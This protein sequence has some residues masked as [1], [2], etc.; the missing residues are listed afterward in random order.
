MKAAYWGLG[1]IFFGLFGLLLISL[2]GDIT[3]TNQQD[4]TLLKNTTEAALYDAV[5]E[6]AYQNGFCLCTNKAKVGGVYKFSDA[7]E[8]KI[9]NPV[10]N[11]C[12]VSGYTYCEKLVDELKINE[13]VFVESFLRRF[14]NSVN[15][16]QNYKIIIQEVVEYP[17]K[18]SIEI[19]TY[20]KFNIFDS[21]AATFTD[22]DFDISNKI[23]AILEYR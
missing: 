6:N 13:E 21:T 7:S 17:P 22:N 12:N 11:S 5:D 19:R 18:V 14:T 10:S 4:Y 20:N 9:S 2:F 8:Y 16:K 23:D 15:G 3:V 1:I